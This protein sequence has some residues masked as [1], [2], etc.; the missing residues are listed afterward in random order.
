[1]SI[2]SLLLS[3]NIENITC[4]ILHQKQMIKHLCK[5]KSQVFKNMSS[6]IANNKL[7]FSTH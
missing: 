1:M 5:T 3:L 2:L 6:D 7:N 4:F